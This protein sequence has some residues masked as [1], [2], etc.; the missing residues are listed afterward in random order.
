MSVEIFQKTR[1][2]ILILALVG[3]LLILRS[4]ANLPVHAQGPVN[5]WSTINNMNQART[6]FT[7][8][9][10]QNGKVLVAGGGDSSGFTNT[11]EIYDPTTGNWTNTPNM[12]SAHA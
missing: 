10:L 4:L 1:S 5:T 11:A 12:N 9:T 8:T 3:L 7:A 6:Q 2:S